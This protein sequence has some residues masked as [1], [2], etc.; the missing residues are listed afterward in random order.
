M[1][2]TFSIDL[3][4]EYTRLSELGLRKGK[5]DL[6]SLGFEA[7]APNFYSN[8]TDQTAKQQAEILIKLKKALN[9]GATEAHVVIPDAMTYSQL[10]LMPNLKEEELVKSIRLQ[11]DEFVPL[12]IDDVYLDL[13]VISKLKNDK[14]LIVFIAAQKRI[15]DH[16]NRTLD[17]ANIEAGTLEN[18]LSAVGRFMS[19]VYP[20]VKTPSLIINLGY[21]ASS[22]YVMNPPFPYF[23]ITRTS[24]IGFEILVKDLIA[25]ANIPHEK[26]VAA[27]ENIG[28]NTKGSIN[29]YATIYPVLNEFF[30]EIEKTIL[31][32]KEKYHVQIKNIYLFNYDKRIALIH[33][34]IQGRVGLPTQSLPLSS[35]I[36]PNPIT[37]T[38]S[39]TLSN[40]IPVIATHLR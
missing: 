7:T 1:A 4:E 12:P 21:S 35:I 6:Y 32:T 28:M 34:T 5:I 9:I 13:E 25:N 16:I 3:S 18:E 11:A 29:I 22:F 24:R 36:T 19:E 17:Y 10:L 15:V 39:R 40:Y 2:A 30:S 14:L 23:Q 26:A 8:F 33:E 27:M 38:F 31:M 37:Q 20:F